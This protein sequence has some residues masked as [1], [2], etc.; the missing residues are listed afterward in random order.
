[1]NAY[2][3]ILCAGFLGL[4]AVCAHVEAGPTND[5]F[6]NRI[7][8]TG[9]NVTVEGNNGGA[10]TEAGEDTG[11]ENFL[12][13]Y[14]V[15]YSW[16][17]PT[18]G[19]MHLSGSTA[20][21]NFYMSLRAYRGTAVNALILAPTLPDGGVA[22]TAGD[23]IAIQVASIYYPVWGGGGGMGPF[24]LALWLEVPGPT[25]LNDA[26]TNR[27]EIAATT[28]H[29]EGSVY[30][31]S[32]ETGEPLPAAGAQQTLWWK[33]VPP[34]NGVLDLALSAPQFA[35]WLTV[36]D[37]AQFQ[38][39]TPVA[40]L[41]GSIFSVQSGRE[42]SIQLATGYVP[43]GAFTLDTRFH[44][45]TNDMFA[46]S[47]QIEG[48]NFTYY[49]NFT[50]ATSEPGEPSSQATNTVW[51]SWAAPCTGRVSYSGASPPL[52]YCNVYTGPTL[53]SLEP[54][55]TVGMGNSVYGFLAREGTVYHFQFSG[56]GDNFT[57]SLSVSPLTPAS[58]DNF[59]DA[60]LVK[61]KVIYFDATSVLGATMELGEPA[62]LG[63]IPQKSIWWKWQAPNWGQFYMTAQASLVTNVV[64]AAYTGDSMA[65]LT[66]V[67]KAPNVL[68]CTVQGG[69]TYYIAGA[70]DTNAV[71]D[72]ANFAQMNSRD[73]SYHPVP[74]NLLQE[75]SWEGTALL[76]A[77]Y[78]H[79]S[80][81][82]GGGVNDTGGCDGGTWP[83]LSTGTTIWQDFSSVPG[84][85]Y[86][87]RFA[88][89]VGGVLT[90]CCGDAHI[91]VSW[92]TNRLGVCDIP[93]AESGF[94][95]WN[96]YTATAS[97]TT[98][99]LS[100]Q[101][102]ARNVEMDAFSVVDISAPPVIAV[103]PSP[104]S[105]VGGGT[106]V[107]V[108]G[109][110]GAAPLQYQWFFANAPLAGQ[111][112]NLLVLSQVTTNQIGN[113][114]VTVTNAFGAVTSAVVSLFVDA[115]T[116]P[117]IVWQPYGDIVAVGGDYRFDVAAIGTPPLSYQWYFQGTLIA[118]A[119]GQT[120]ELTNVQAI[121]AGSYRVT[122]RN[123]AGT[124]W[125]LPATLSVG[126]TNQGGGMVVFQNKVPGGMPPIDAPVFD[127]DG[128]TRL[129]GG[130][131]Q[132]QLYAGPTLEWLR[133]V[134]QPAAFRTGFS[135]GYVVPQ[136]ITLAN[137][138]PGGSFVA[139][140]RAWDGAVAGSYEA[141]RALGGKFGKSGILS[142]TAGG[143]WLLPAF[144][145]GLQNFSLQAGLP[146]FTVGTIQFV[147]RQPHGI[148]VWSVT[149]EPGY[150]YLVEKAGHDFVFEP[151]V[152]LTN[153]TGTVTFTDS[154]N[155]GSA[156]TF[157]RAR[158]LD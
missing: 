26:F 35:A 5:L 82:L 95:H 145:V 112:S 15:W 149:G 67:G 68:R 96:D 147:E 36:F 37:G 71:G 85:A 150:R 110:T 103:Q 10:G 108:V 75:P 155:S 158:I 113:Y 55:R 65:A 100:F 27:L 109:V 69:Q 80:G 152:V 79:W 126:E 7:V 138:P 121:N 43:A 148:I 146:R 61:G 151:Y 91:S 157:H 21:Y 78:W 153:M 58:N 17:A 107:F 19:V 54:V 60:Q 42:Y 20:V 92:N 59:A 46:G 73:T 98:T 89:L 1:M 130:T 25:S 111:T 18:N 48:T 114:F 8:L 28:S 4:L 76:G 106:A 77:Q 86:R 33:F 105:T 94:W 16:T 104:I 39:M 119:T 83:T 88:Y 34:N 64:L 47:E 6:A 23:T 52:K 66:L 134:G 115:P 31:A 32:S 117:A 29:Y 22:V 116:Q 120:L 123:P 140:V 99:R 142:L 144:L 72:I 124:V 81:S 62:H 93:E 125:S 9:T 87:V 102:L 122:V 70:V 24:M 101:N 137:V 44:N 74:G 136:T 49:G 133:P 14:S 56:G 45:S 127:I 97:N 141:A 30:G 51:V 40:P 154:A 84:H 2:S 139:Q 41:N 129:N 13:F 38:S 12:W 50:A 143:G 53:A 135:A 156:V 132:A 90:G 131:C 118:G 57:F 128:F 3:R 63:A 11:S